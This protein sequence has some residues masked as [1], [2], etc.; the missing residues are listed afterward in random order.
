MLRTV[1]NGK[2]HRATVTQADLHYVGSLTIDRNLMAAADIREGERVQ[3][4]DITNGN[5][6]ETYAITGDAGSGVIGVNGAAAHLV[7]PGDLVII[8]TY[9]GLAC[10]E[11]D[12]HRPRIVHVDKQNQV[13]ELGD[14]PAAP[15]QGDGTLRSGRDTAAVNA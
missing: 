14:D 10:D 2:I 12:E 5:R 7:H 11:L 9:V 1:L 15:A 8:I 4:V 13:V 6:L 3:V